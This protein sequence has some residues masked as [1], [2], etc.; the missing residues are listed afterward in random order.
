MITGEK[1]QKEEK[2]GNCRPN[3]QV[4]EGTCVFSPCLEK[5]AE[6]NE[7]RALGGGGGVGKVKR[8]DPEGGLRPP[9]RTQDRN[10]TLGRWEE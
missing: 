7:K 10:S 5:R 4:G 3:R 8:T 6:R 9:I 2:P 1:T